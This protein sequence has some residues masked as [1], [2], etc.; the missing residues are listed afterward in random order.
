[1]AKTKEVT[2]PFT[3]Q[4]VHTTLLMLGNRFGG[5]H[6]DVRTSVSETLLTISS[7]KRGLAPVQLINHT[8]HQMI[9]YGEKGQGRIFLAF[10]AIFDHFSS[11]NNGMWFLA[12][13]ESSY[14]T[15]INPKGDRTLVWAAD[16]GKAHH[17]NEN[18]LQTDGEDVIELGHNKYLAW[19]SFLDGM[20]R[21]LLFTDDPGLCYNLAHTTGEHE[22]IAQVS[23][24][25]IY[26]N[27][28][29]VHYL[30]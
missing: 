17:E 5:M 2:A 9:Q 20:Q 30:I 6:V 14:Y 27:V 29:R 8:K 21:V 7:Y 10:L 25:D 15:W 16:A 3:L 23:C 22:R 4:N 18:S 1:M 13:G 11:A 24:L 12:P 26:C 28:M 19:V